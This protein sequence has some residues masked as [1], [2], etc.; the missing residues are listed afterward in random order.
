[1]TL[2]V[3]LLDENIIVDQVDRLRRRRIRCRHIGHDFEPQ[4]IQDDNIL[5]VLHRLRPPTLLTRDLGLYRRSIC[6]PNYCIICLQ[7]R[8]LDVAAP[9][10]LVLRQPVFSTAA[11]RMG[12][13]VKV[14]VT[15]IHIWERHA[16]GERFVRWE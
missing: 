13:V 6:H 9:A 8:E 14:N 4:G 3:I 15:L 5:P 2:A 7:V 16:R 12:L 1:M 10:R 11:R